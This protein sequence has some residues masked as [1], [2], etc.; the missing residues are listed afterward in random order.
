ML[1]RRTGRN[2]RFT[3]P[4]STQH[5]LLHYKHTHE[6]GDGLSPIWNGR[7]IRFIH[8]RARR[9]TYDVLLASLQ[10]QSLSRR[11]ICRESSFSEHRND[12]NNFVFVSPSSFLDSTGVQSCQKFILPTANCMWPAMPGGARQSRNN[13]Q[14]STGT[15]GRH[16]PVDIVLGTPTTLLVQKSKG[17]CVRMFRTRERW[18]TG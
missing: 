16:C 8:L 1:F 6:R 5:I 12:S 11:L 18:W 9:P 4:R 15:A 7:F 3:P 17:D 14:S 2:E 13:L 10:L